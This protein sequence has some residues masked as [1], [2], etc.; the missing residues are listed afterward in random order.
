MIKEKPAQSHMVVMDTITVPF[1]LFAGTEAECRKE[2]KKWVT[3]VKRN[4]W[5]AIP[6]TLP[7]DMNV[8]H[9][10]AI[11]VVELSAQAQRAAQLDQDPRNAEFI[12]RANGMAE[13]VTTGPDNM[14]LGYK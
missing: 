3:K 12:N 13:A 2:Q 11:R 9:I 10:V 5:I 8:S 7:G 1:S 14:D 4:Q 6:S